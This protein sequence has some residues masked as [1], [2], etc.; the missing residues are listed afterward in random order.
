MDGA[1]LQDESG[2]ISWA[3]LGF[4][5]CAGEQQPQA[6]VTS[7][8]LGPRSP[9]P[10]QDHPETGYLSQCSYA[11][12]GA[13][14]TLTIQKIVTAHLINYFHFSVAFALVFT[15]DSVLLA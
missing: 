15:V 6:P 9:S 8:S 10:L 1:I 14:D 3:T 4:S 5:A 7:S 11:L 2:A 12:R 13:L